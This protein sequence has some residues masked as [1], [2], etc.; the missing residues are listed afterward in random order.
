MSSHAAMGCFSTSG[1]PSGPN[2]AV[3]L[4]SGLR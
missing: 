4:P 1:V 2:T 3:P